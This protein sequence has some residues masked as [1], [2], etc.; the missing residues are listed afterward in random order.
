MDPGDVTIRECHEP[1]IALDPAEFDLKPQYLKQGLTADTKVWLR[2]SVIHKLH[3]VKRQLPAGWTVRIW[4][5]WR[6]LSLQATL[7]ERTLEQLRR[8]HAA[9]TDD[10]LRALARGYLHPPTLNPPAP[11][12]T[13]GTVDLT[14]ADATGQAVNFGTGF[15][16]FTERAAINYFAHHAPI[17]SED[18]AALANRQ[19]L[20]FLMEAEDFVV[21]PQEWWHWSYGTAQWAAAKGI[22]VARYGV[23]TPKKS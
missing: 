6:P 14:L 11:H 12:S 2:E 20:R 17:T 4:D 7:Y 8:T 3:A 9:A 18:T 22:V 10:E 21:N 16:E 23:T 15:D 19:L 5:G 13:G 1:L